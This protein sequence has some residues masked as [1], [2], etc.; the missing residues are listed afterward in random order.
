MRKSS[1]KEV[2]INFVVRKMIYAYIYPV[3]LKNNE[4]SCKYS[5]I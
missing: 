5:A 4:R 2:F 1:L 3:D